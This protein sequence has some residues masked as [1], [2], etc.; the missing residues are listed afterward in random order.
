MPSPHREMSPS[1]ALVPSLDHAPE[2]LIR[3]GN[4]LVNPSEPHRP[5]TR[6]PAADEAQENSLAICA[7]DMQGYT[8]AY[9]SWTRNLA[10]PPGEEIPP[11]ARPHEGSAIWCTNLDIEGLQDCCFSPIIPREETVQATLMRDPTI[12]ALL[13]QH[14]GH[15]KLYLVNA[16]MVAHGLSIKGKRYHYPEEG[17]PWDTLDIAI[18]NPGPVII[19]YQVLEI[20]IHPAQ[21]VM[22]NVHRPDMLDPHFFPDTWAMFG[23]KV[24]SRE[25]EAEYRRRQEGEV[26][27]QRVLPSSSSSSF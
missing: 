26:T 6:I 18:I 9:G 1:W 11:W 13:E 22:L 5:L 10:F 25:T 2:G 8:H 14:G 20:V 21:R 16:I 17:R 15:C 7:S 3:V 19:A 4:I 12:Q 23:H 24:L 27:A